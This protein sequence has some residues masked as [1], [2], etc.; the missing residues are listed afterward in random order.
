LKYRHTS[1]VIIPAGYTRD[2][3]DGTKFNLYQHN[4]GRLSTRGGDIERGSV[5][6]YGTLCRGEYCGSE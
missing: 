1:P 4:S 5:R 6:R 3:V 2:H